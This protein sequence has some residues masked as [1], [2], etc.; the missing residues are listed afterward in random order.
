VK[1]PDQPEIDDPRRKEYDF[2]Q[3]KAAQSQ[4]ASGTFGGHHSAILPD[5][6]NQGESKKSRLEAMISEAVQSAV[7]QITTS[8]AA[9]EQVRFSPASNP[10]PAQMPIDVPREANKAEPQVMPAV[11]Q[12]QVIQ[13][14]L[15]QPAQQPVIVQQQSTIEPRQYQTPQFPEMPVAESRAHN[16]LPQPP[17]QDEVNAHTWAPPEPPRQSPLRF[18]D[19]LAAP[20]RPIQEIRASTFVEKPRKQDAPTEQPQD[21]PE[22]MRRTSPVFPEN[23]AAWSPSEP[24]LDRG[25]KT[26]D[27][28]RS[29]AQSKN[30]EQ[31]REFSE[32][33]DS[34]SIEMA[35][36]AAAT[37]DSVRTLTRRLNDLT[38]ALQG[39]GYDIR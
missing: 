32:A 19:K 18:M 23:R 35:A 9:I 21:A 33:M 10:Q 15:Q 11:G 24:F 34:Y 4:M 29:A 8:V 13:P 7:T 27:P 25:D 2:L 38:R 22:P 26:A 14:Q 39:E 37:V 16:T 30:T 1:D 6:T 31:A 28:Q 12:Q 20:D 17:S 5:T 3:A 36:F